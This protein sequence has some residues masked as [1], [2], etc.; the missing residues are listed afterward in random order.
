[1]VFNFIEYKV[2]SSLCGGFTVFI[3]YKYRN[4]LNTIIL[5]NVID[6]NKSVKLEYLLLL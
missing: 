3:F 6:N 4:D 5:S 2:I 1:M